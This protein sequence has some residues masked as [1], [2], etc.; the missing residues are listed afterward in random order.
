MDYPKFVT[1]CDAYNIQVFDNNKNSSK[2]EENTKT[3]E[4]SY[5]H[6]LLVKEKK[7]MAMTPYFGSP[8]GKYSKLLF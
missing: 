7:R 4:A 6:K 3:K 2:K 8:S 1:Y 5:R